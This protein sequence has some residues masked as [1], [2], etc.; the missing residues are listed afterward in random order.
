MIHV[1]RLTKVYQ[2]CHET[3]YIAL[4]GV[5]FDAMPGQVFGLLGPNGAGKTTALRILSTVLRP[6]SGIAV[7]NGH[8]VTREPEQIRRQ[9]GFVSLNTAIYD[10]MTAWE[11]VYFFGRLNGISPEA[12]HVRMDDLFDRFQMNDFRQTLGSRMSTGMKQKVS[13]ARALIHDPPVL[14]F[15]EASAGLDILAAREVFRTI[16]Q[17]RDQGK[18][19][20]YSSHIMSEVRRLCDVVAIMNRGKILRQA[21]LQELLEESRGQ[22]LEDIFF[23]LIADS[24]EQAALGATG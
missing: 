4:N 18:C 1:R 7:I 24:E 20:I 12:L 2:H 5:S 11:M 23:D 9:I 8:D 10:R 15:D 16:E 13:I 21:P 22:D 17:L 3:E 14:I 19:I 6:T